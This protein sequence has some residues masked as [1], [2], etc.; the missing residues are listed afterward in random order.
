[1]NKLKDQINNCKP[2]CKEIKNE[3]IKS[4]NDEINGFAILC[5]LTNTEVSKIV[6][7]FQG[8]NTIVEEIP[9][10]FKNISDKISEELKISSEHVFVQLI[11]IKAGGRVKTH[12]D[13]ACPGY[14]TYKCNL[15]IDGPEIDSVF[16]DQE[17]FN[18]TNG[19]LYCFEA[20][21]YKHWVNQCDKDRI[22]ISYGFILPYSDLNWDENS[23]RIRL[24]NR[25]WKYFQENY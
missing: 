18:I 24:S 1:M 11:K 17:E 14:I 9:D 8:D 5:N 19:D 13:A 10:V 12:Y 4:I 3:H 15:V 6:A 2:T 16:V 21:L 22:L 23:P 20:S 25:L 7:N